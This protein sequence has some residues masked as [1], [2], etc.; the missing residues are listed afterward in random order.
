[1]DMFTI[2]IREQNKGV[3]LNNWLIQES[4]GHSMSEKIVTCYGAAQY[5][6]ILIFF[7]FGSSGIEQLFHVFLTYCLLN[8]CNCNIHL[9]HDGIVQTIIRTSW[10][11]KKPIN[12]KESFSIMQVSAN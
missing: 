4:D 5:K 6:Q 10:I 3:L 11:I 9:L 12:I 1:M 7:F 2:I 8:L